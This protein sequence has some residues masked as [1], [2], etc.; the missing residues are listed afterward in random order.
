M[1]TRTA[2]LRLSVDKEGRGELRFFALSLHVESPGRPHVSQAHLS[3][4][5]HDTQQYLLG[6]ESEP[7]VWSA[8]HPRAQG[9]P[10]VTESR[11]HVHHHPITVAYFLQDHA[12][13][14]GFQ[15]AA[16]VRGSAS[17]ISLR[18]VLQSAALLA[19]HAIAIDLR[20]SSTCSLGIGTLNAYVDTGPS[21]SV[22]ILHGDPMASGRAGARGAHT[23]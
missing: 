3:E 16:A 17:S 22:R 14:P 5:A 8:S 13:E 4:R 1:A 23:S 12:I 18:P 7:P 15:R 6:D 11:N 21:V 9:L 19:L 20:I 2:P 10:L